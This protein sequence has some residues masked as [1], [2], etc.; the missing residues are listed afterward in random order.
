[1]RSSGGAGGQIVDRSLGFA[2]TV[3]GTIAVA[4]AVKWLHDSLKRANSNTNRRLKSQEASEILNKM[5]NNNSNLITGTANVAA[6]EDS[7]SARIRQHTSSSNTA[8]TR[9]GDENM[10]VHLGCCH[11]QRVKFKIFGPR[12]LNAVDISSK[13]RFPR[14]SIV[15]EDFELLCDPSILSMYTV[16]Q[17]SAG[18]AINAPV[19]A[20]GPIDSITANTNTNPQ[21]G[22]YTFCSFCGMHIIYAPSVDPVEVQINVDCLVADNIEQVHIAYHS[23]NDMVAANQILDRRGIG[24]MDSPMLPLFIHR[25][26]KRVNVDGRNGLDEGALS[27]PVSSYG[28]GHQ[29]Q[30]SEGHIHTNNVPANPQSVH[31][32][33]SYRAEQEIPYYVKQSGNSDRYKHDDSRLHPHDRNPSYHPRNNSTKHYNYPLPPYQEG[34]VEGDESILSMTSSTMDL[35]SSTT[36]LGSMNHFHH[37]QHQSNIKKDPSLAP[38]ATSAYSYGYTTSTASAYYPAPTEHMLQRAHNGG[39]QRHQPQIVRSY[40]DFY[41][42]YY[43]DI[44]TDVNSPAAATTAAIVHHQ[45]GS[46]STTMVLD[47]EFDP[48]GDRYSVPSPLPSDSGES[49]NNTKENSYHSYSYNRGRHSS[50][51]SRHSHSHLLHSPIMVGSSRS[52]STPT[53]PMNTQQLPYGNSGGQWTSTPG[54]SPS[55]SRS[56]GGKL[57]GSTSTSPLKYNG[58]HSHIH[59]RSSNANSSSVSVNGSVSQSGGK[60]KITSGLKLHQSVASSTS[61]PTISTVNASSS[62]QY[63]PAHIILPASAA[64]VDPEATVMDLHQ[65]SARHLKLKR[66]LNRHTKSDKGDDQGHLTNSNLPITV[67]AVEVPSVTG[68]IYT[69]ESVHEKRAD[70]VEV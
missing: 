24:A 54:P 38:A 17:P 31:H 46:H 49:S 11:C 53:S 62:A 65:V 67:A 45:T 30:T 48:E 19:G 28:M 5:E 8:N 12:V 32:H 64:S 18:D 36:G 60:S 37:Q 1:M 20:S 44:P 25:Q 56:Q 4:Y 61:S 63:Y 27:S 9:Y 59:S 55:N 21:V 10:V 23:V 6:M 2:V 22:I 58:S 15:Y 40:E 35:D 29:P 68:N 69:G 14:I 16:Q 57:S 51:G 13:L 41:S 39:H 70:P 50:G 66:H 52:S 26:P 42:Q 33:H 43:G 47:A 3:T 7:T 34:F